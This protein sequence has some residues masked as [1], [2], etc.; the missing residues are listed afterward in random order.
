ME[1]QLP[2]ESHFALWLDVKLSTDLPLMSLQVWYPFVA[3]D[4]ASQFRFSLALEDAAQPR[5]RFSAEP[6]QPGGLA[7]ALR[8]GDRAQWSYTFAPSEP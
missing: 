1:H 4:S 5:E 3:A 6:R 2:R 8:L 7:P